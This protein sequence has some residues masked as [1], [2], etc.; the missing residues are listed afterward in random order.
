MGE[1]ILPEYKRNG[2]ISQSRCK[3]VLVILGYI[4]PNLEFK[5]LSP[6]YGVLIMILASSL[7]GVFSRGSLVKEAAATN[8]KVSQRVD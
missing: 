4:C 3:D 1:E 6:L 8:E 2:W 7:F 5:V